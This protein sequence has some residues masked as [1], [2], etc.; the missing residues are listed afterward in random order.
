MATLHIISRSPAESRTLE[1]CLT[2][3]GEGDAVLLIEDGVY[4]ADGS[5]AEGML[6]AA[7]GRMMLYVLLPDLEAR[8]LEI[9]GLPV[10]AERDP[11]AAP[12]FQPVDYRGFV[13][14]TT[15]HQPIVSWF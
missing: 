5:A 15:S 13:A 7:A 10:R 1:Q 6:R 12:A 2:R 8:G 9:P 3:A 14:L 4:A 11:L